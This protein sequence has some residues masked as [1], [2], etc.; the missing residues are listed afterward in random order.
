MTGS[1][2]FNILVVSHNPRRKWLT[3]G[4]NAQ[5]QFFNQLGR[6]DI[7][8]MRTKALFGRGKGLKGDEGDSVVWARRHFQASRTVDAARRWLR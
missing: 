7:A 4:E 6:S 2:F 5:R 1:K 8:E 3:R